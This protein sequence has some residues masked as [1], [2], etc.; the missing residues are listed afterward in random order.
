MHHRRTAGG[1]R[2]LPSASASHGPG[3]PHASRNL[4][5]RP[6][7]PCGPGSPLPLPPQHQHQHPHQHQHQHQLQLQLQA[8]SSRLQALRSTST[9]LQ[10]TSPSKLQ[11]SSSGSSPRP[12]TQHPAHAS[13]STTLPLLLPRL[14]R[15]LDLALASTRRL[16]QTKLRHQHILDKLPPSP[17]PPQAA[18]GA[19]QFPPCRHV[20]DTLSALPSR[21]CRRTILLAALVV[22]AVNGRGLLCNLVV[23]GKR[24]PAVALGRQPLPARHGP[25]TRHDHRQRYR[26]PAHQA[27][28]TGYRWMHA[29][30]PQSSHVSTVCP[31]RCCSASAREGGGG[32]QKTA[33]IKLRRRLRTASWLMPLSQRIGNRRLP[34]LYSPPTGARLCKCIHI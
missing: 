1:H 28:C 6:Q 31:R 4:E 13:P 19:G 14:A 3:R 24:R 22:P 15:N 32:G 17:P 18:R 10:S 9:K 30:M 11:L 7:S 8:P 34:S 29:C 12:S 25:R 16:P 23:T 20:L 27:S 26:L 5:S 21:V 33:A 2:Q